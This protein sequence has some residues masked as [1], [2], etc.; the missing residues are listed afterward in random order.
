MVEFRQD[1]VAPTG[2]A[3]QRAALDD[4]GHVHGEADGKPQHRRQRGED[5]CVAGSAGDD[6]I[7]IGLQRL[8]ERSHAHL[9]DDV[10]GLGDV[11]LGQIRHRIETGYFA[12]SGIASKQEGAGDVGAHHRHAEVQ[13]VGM[14]DAADHRQRGVKMRGQRRPI[15]RCR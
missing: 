14:G 4:L 3:A 1:R 6:D 2:N 11:F 9:A 12:G 7:D 5:G 10:S 8:A 13:A 15:R